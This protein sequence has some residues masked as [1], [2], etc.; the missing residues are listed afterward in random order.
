MARGVHMPRQ[1]D[2]VWVA[3]LGFVLVAT[4][5]AAPSGR[6]GPRAKWGTIR[7]IVVDDHG[8]PLARAMVTAEPPIL[9]GVPPTTRTNAQGGFAITHL[10]WVKY[11]VYAS[12]IS[13][14]YP[15]NLGGFYGTGGVATVNLSPAAPR[16]YVRIRLGPRAGILHGRVTNAVTGKPIN[17]A[18]FRL[19]WV[20]S[21]ND[22][23]MTSQ[24]STYRVFLPPSTAVDLEVSAPGFVPARYRGLKLPSGAES[25]L[26]IRLNP[27]R[28]SG[29]R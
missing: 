11:K 12:K 3:L 1:L 7:G 6:A 22:W 4:V 8:S 24:P 28:R 29:P 10:G 9:A 27:R 16:A 14:G 17:A 26:N 25:T 21:P 23:M 20:G 5:A 2:K 19:V 15:E 18:D 13:A